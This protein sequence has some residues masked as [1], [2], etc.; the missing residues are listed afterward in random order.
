MNTNELYITADLAKI[1]ITD[2]EMKLLSENVSNLLTYF[3]KM[4]EINVDE[5]QPTTHTLLEKNNVREDNISNS[6][7]QDAILECSPELEDRFIV[8]PNV[9]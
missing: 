7:I 9:L 4:M 2:Q 3:A 1:E 8:I 6:G 5:L